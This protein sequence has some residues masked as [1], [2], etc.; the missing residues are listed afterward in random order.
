MRRRGEQ[1]VAVRLGAKHE[2][3][4]QIAAGTGAALDD[5]LLAEVCSRDSARMGLAVSRLARHS[6]MNP[7]PEPF[8]PPSGSGMLA[9]FAST[10]GSPWAVR[11]TPSG[12]DCPLRRACARAPIEIMLDAMS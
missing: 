3:R 2:L 10:V 6:A 5:E 12:S 11:T 1:R 8:G 9:V 4:A 7:S